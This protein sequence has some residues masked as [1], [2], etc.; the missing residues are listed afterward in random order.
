MKRK[1]KANAIKWRSLQSTCSYLPDALA[2]FNNLG[3]FLII[4][5]MMYNPMTRLISMVHSPYQ[6][7]QVWFN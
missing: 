5:S 3:L 2:R 4:L 6:D 1:N 7:R